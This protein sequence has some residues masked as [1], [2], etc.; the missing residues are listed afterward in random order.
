MEKDHRGNPA[1]PRPKIAEV[2][3]V[4]GREAP[5]KVFV[6]SMNNHSRNLYLLIG[7]ILFLAPQPGCHSPTGPSEES[8]QMIPIGDNNQWTYTVYGIDSM[9]NILPGPSGSETETQSSYDL[10]YSNW[11]TS[12]WDSAAK[13]WEPFRNETGECREVSDADAFG[14][15]TGRILYSGYTDG[16]GTGLICGERYGTDGRYWFR[17]PDHPTRPLFFDATVAFPYYD[18]IS[19]TGVYHAYLD[20]TLYP[21]SVPA[22]SFECYKLIRRYDGQIGDLRINPDSIITVDTIYLTPG[23][24]II[25]RITT[26]LDK[27]EMNLN[28]HEW[29]IDNNSRTLY[30]LSSYQIQ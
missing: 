12:V 1:I 22:G 9:G 11:N 21:I 7:A 26:R 6:N 14:G 27:M 4:A 2:M 18:T 25:K 29:L 3:R 16:S 23:K 8:Q 13:F 20:T 17:L 15:A 5:S 28:T 19:D 24:G 10:N 30:E